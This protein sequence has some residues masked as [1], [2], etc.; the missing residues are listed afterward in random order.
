MTR[1]GA[2]N[3][4]AIEQTTV[5]KPPGSQNYSRTLVFWNIG[6][7]LG[8]R[9]FWHFFKNDKYRQFCATRIMRNR[10]RWPPL[11]TSLTFLW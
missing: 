2:G 11:G 6:E 9:W 3:D 7:I 1:W 10:D 8:P 5:P 4:P